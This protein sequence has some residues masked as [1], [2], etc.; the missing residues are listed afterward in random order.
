MSKICPK[1]KFK[2]QTTEKK[3]FIFR[4]FGQDEVDPHLKKVD[5]L[6]GEQV[7]YLKKIRVAVK[8]ST[9]TKQCTGCKEY[10]TVSENR[11]TAVKQAEDELL[12]QIIEDMDRVGYKKIHVERVLGL[13]FGTL[14]KWCAGETEPVSLPLMKMIRA[15]PGLLEVADCN[16]SEE[17]ANRLVLEEYEKIMKRKKKD[18][19]T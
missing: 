18:E 8:Y 3:N 16:F 4:S 6:L 1:C 15:F 13:E 7:Q 19:V 2:I 11:Q 14:K 12:K 17:V 5:Q 9:I 10:Q